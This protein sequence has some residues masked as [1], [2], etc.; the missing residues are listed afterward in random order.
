MSAAARSVT[1]T[2]LLLEVLGRL[3]WKA[4]AYLPHR[5]D[6]GYGLSQAGVENCLSKFP[7][8]LLLAAGTA[9]ANDPMKNWLGAHPHQR[10]TQRL[11][12]ASKK[13]FAQL[14]AAH[15]T[16]YQHLASIRLR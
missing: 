7:V 2:A 16:D 6:E 9:F 3:G 11:E 12:S 5:M 4:N 13:T 10:V 14:Q 1:S 15:M 8:T